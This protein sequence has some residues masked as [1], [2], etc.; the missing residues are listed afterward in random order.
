MS[1]LKQ[2]IEKLLAGEKLETKYRNHP[3]FHNWRAHFEC[4]I[5]SDWLSIYKIDTH[6]KKVVFVRT[7]SHSE[8]F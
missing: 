4:H 2:V 7:G 3:L 8:L 6:S 5:E 1:K